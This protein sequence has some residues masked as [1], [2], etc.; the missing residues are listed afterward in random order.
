MIALLEQKFSKVN[1]RIV[2]TL[3][4]CR[5]SSPVCAVYSR[6]P[7]VSAYCLFLHMV[8]LS[9][10]F[11]PI[12]YVCA[13]CLIPHKMCLWFI[14]IPAWGMSVLTVHSHIRIVCHYSVFLREVC[15]HTMSVRTHSTFSLVYS[16]WDLP[17]LWLFIKGA[18]EEKRRRCLEKSAGNVST[19]KYLPL[20]CFLYQVSYRVL[21]YRLLENL[22]TLLWKCWSH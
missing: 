3:R 21:L 7:Y 9:L 1:F 5:D 12:R 20:Y 8:C 16:H 2:T 10:L 11:I 13:Y 18:G 22:S 6:M 17:S 19:P 14:C 15:F 4:R